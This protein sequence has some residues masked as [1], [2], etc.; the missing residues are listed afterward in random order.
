MTN[1][2]TIVLTRRTFVSKV[3]SLLFNTLSRLVIAFL[4]RSKRLFISL[5]QSDISIANLD[6]FS[7]VSFSTA[8][9]STSESRIS[10][11]ASS[12]LL[13]PKKEK[14]KSRDRDKEKDRDK[15]RDPKQVTAPSGR[16]GCAPAPLQALVP[17]AGPRRP[18]SPGSS[19]RFPALGGGAASV[20]LPQVSG[21]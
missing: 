10:A 6:F 4:P 19:V 1:G 17:E 13:L 14:E 5:L 21:G 12:H 9:K 11:V 7:Q 15:G 18:R 2:K 16:A 8:G 3:M 20:P